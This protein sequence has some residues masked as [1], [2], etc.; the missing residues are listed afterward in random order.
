M[1]PAN[2]IEEPVNKPVFN[3]FQITSS[4]INGE[5]LIH[6][7]SSTEIINMTKEVMPPNDTS[8]LFP[9]ISKHL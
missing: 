8:L 5:S 6:P 3:P 2:N 7:L 4:F 1:A 9:D